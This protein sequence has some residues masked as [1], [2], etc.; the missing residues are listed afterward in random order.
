MTVA[1]VPYEIESMCVGLAVKAMS[2]SFIAKVNDF[3]SN[4]TVFWRREKKRFCAWL[5]DWKVGSRQSDFSGLRVVIP[6]EMGFAIFPVVDGP[7]G[8]NRKG[9]KP[10]DLLRG[11][12]PNTFLI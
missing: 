9:L 5:N 10:V 8:A 7:S 2:G 4:I 11:T 12:G 3:Y 1:A 6:F